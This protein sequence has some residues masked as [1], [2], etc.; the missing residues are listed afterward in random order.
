M[1]L[2]IKGSTQEVRVPCETRQQMRA[3]QARIHM[4][5]GAMAREKHPQYEVVTRARTSQSWKLME[6]TNEACDF[7]LY[8]RPQDSQFSSILQKAGVTV[9]VEDKDL[10]APPSE[11]PLSVELPSES[12]SNV[13]DRF[14]P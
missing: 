7:A 3:L 4:L 11:E 14:K 13:Y 10:L 1:A 12:P 5:R 6:G 8:V 9:T 2:L